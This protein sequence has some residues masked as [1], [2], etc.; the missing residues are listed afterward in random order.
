MRGGSRREAYMFSVSQAAAY[1]SSVVKFMT[2]PAEMGISS[3]F[4]VLP[5]RISGPLVSRAMAT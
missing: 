4:L 5:V 1:C 2:L 3:S